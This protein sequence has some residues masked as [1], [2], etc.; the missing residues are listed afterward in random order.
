MDEHV[1]LVAFHVKAANRQHAHYALTNRLIDEE[2][3]G[4]S[5]QEWWVAED[6][7]EDGSDNDSAVFCRLGNQEQAARALYLEGLA[8]K[9]N[10]VARPLSR[11]RSVWTF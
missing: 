5:I 6:D 2:L 7:R 10:L 8:E 4:D 3:L 1:I 11:H 9:H